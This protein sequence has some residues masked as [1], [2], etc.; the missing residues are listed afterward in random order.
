MTA[1]LKPSLPANI[2]MIAF[3]ACGAYITIVLAVIVPQW[4]E[5]GVADD[6]ANYIV[7]SE[8]AGMMLSALGL[9]AIINKVSW[10]RLGLVY[11]LSLAVTSALTANTTDPTLLALLR[12]VCGIAEGGVISLMTAAAV[13]AGTADRTFGLYLAATLILAYVGF[14]CFDLLLA[15]GGLP[16]V[17]YAM[18]AISLLVALLVPAFPLNPRA[19][20]RDGLSADAGK[21]VWR[22]L[23][24]ALVATALFEACIMAIWNNIVNTAAVSGFSDESIGFGMNNGLFAGIFGGLAAFA[25]AD[26]Y[27]RGMALV[28]GVLAMVASLAIVIVLPGGVPF[29]L[30]STLFMFSWMFTLPYFVGAVAAL[31]TT[32]RSAT[33]SIG[34]Q[35][36]GLMLGPLLSG[37]I[38]GATDNDYSALPYVGIALLLGCLVLVL[39][40]VSAKATGALGDA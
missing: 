29:I 26:R 34:F 10:R 6:V 40:S 37:A 18:S 22:F 38:L 9:T 3:G 19:T 24:L 31:D 30:V 11:F 25:L 8:K 15:A 35:T 2:A 20:R 36:G 17:F 28:V 13:S 5:A 4:I 23:W 27:G 39:P 21:T 16:Y 14:Q 1:A 33:L 12:F 7:A 32:G